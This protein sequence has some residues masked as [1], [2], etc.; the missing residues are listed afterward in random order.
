MCGRFALGAQAEQLAVDIH[1]QYFVPPPQ[2][3]PSQPRQAGSADG[4]GA[5]ASRQANAR[6]AEVEG[7]PDSSGGPST[8]GADGGRQL[9]WAS[10]EAQSSFRPRY[11]VAPTTRVPVLRRSKKN[12]D[13]Y[14]LDLLKWGLVPHWYSEPPAPGLS[15]I[16]ATCE[17]VFQGT[18][19][20]RGPRQDKRCVVVA[21]GF[22]EWLD[23]GKEKQPYFVKRKDGKLMALAGLWDHC[24]FKGEC[25][26]N[27]DPVTSFTILTVPVNTQLKF[28]HTRMPAILSNASE[29]ESWL[30]AEP[31]SEKLKTLIRPFEDEL[32]C[33]AVDRGVGKVQNDSEEFVKPLAQKKGSL[34]SLFAKQAN[35]ANKERKAKLEPSLPPRAGSSPSSP[36]S[37]RA[38]KPES[39]ARDHVAED[40]QAMNPDEDD[41]RTK[42]LKVEEEATK[43]TRT[44]AAASRIGSSG[45][46]KRTT[47]SAEKEH[48]E[49]HE[50]EQE[51]DGHTDKEVEVI[52]LLSDGP[53]GGESEGAGNAPRAAESEGQQPPR[54]KRQKKQSGPRPEKPATTRRPATKAK[55]TQDMAAGD[56]EEKEE[57]EKVVHDEKAG[58]EL[59]TP[60]RHRTDGHGNAELTDFFKVEEKE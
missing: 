38:P 57:E 16:N 5:T 58:T 8:G 19:A 44:D 60:H 10:H 39:E 25:R 52:D 45:K 22:Y 21:Q 24:D 54:R 35:R 29:I 27:H 46:R 51:H 14:E 6:G 47:R 37:G 42:L 56:D 55:K 11:N 17:S 13:Q 28:L 15:T 41:N 49:E 31:W 18:P 12:L 40:A 3:Q 7:E 34:D 33:Y 9:Q 30:S 59:K 36:S 48:R 43:R 20:W 32:E 26:G 50:Q 1:Q 2:Q 23:K 53:S 4:S